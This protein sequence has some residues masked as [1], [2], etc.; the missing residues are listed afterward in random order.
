MT[1]RE[2]EGERERERERE[3]EMPTSNLHMRI[4]HI[5]LWDGGHLLYRYVEEEEL[6]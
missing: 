1:E 4:L 3:R 2:R 6:Y 5:C